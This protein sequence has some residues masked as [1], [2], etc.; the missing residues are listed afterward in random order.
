[1]EVIDITLDKS[2]TVVKHPTARPSGIEIALANLGSDVKPWVRLTCVTGE[3]SG[4]VFTVTSQVADQKP[5][6]DL[7][8]EV[9]AALKNLA[10]K[11]AVYFAGLDTMKG[12]TPE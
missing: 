9:Q 7:P 8:V 6:E 2:Q 4:D 5:I 1:M 12:S 10:D 3:Q 11:L